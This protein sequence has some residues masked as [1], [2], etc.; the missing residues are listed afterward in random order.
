MSELRMSPG[1]LKRYALDDIARLENDIYLH[2]WLPDVVADL[3][4]VTVGVWRCVD[5]HDGASLAGSDCQGPPGD[6]GCCEA[7]Y[8]WE[9]PIAEGWE[10][11]CYCGRPAMLVRL[12]GEWDFSYVGLSEN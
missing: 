4:S 3:S 11:E 5:A 12:E 7:D 6:C 8:L 1:Q 9:S 10:P 2:T